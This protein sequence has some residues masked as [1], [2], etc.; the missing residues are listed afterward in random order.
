MAKNE[1]TAEE[2]FGF[3]I[4]TRYDADVALEGVWTPPVLDERDQHY[5]EFKLV[6][7][8]TDNPAIK[9]AQEKVR[10]KNEKA[11]RLKQ[12]TSD[13]LALEVFLEAILID[14][15]G[16]T[17]GGVE[18]PYSREAAKQYFSVSAIRKV[19]FPE[20]LEFAIN[21]LNYGTPDKD[22]VAGN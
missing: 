16:V 11:V 17:K 2:N 5:G 22:E 4:P 6:M 8:D 12:V 3:D 10:I 7:F 13:D 18:V 15:K 14:W 20:L 1:V 21:V 19:V 9:K